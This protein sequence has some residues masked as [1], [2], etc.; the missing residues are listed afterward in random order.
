MKNRRVPVILASVLAIVALAGSL[1]A[2]SRPD[3]ISTSVDYTC[4][5]GSRN[6]TIEVDASGG[7]RIV[8]LPPSTSF[9]GRSVGVTKSDASA[10]TVTL[11][12]YGDD[13]ISGAATATLST[14]WEFDA[15]TAAKAGGWYNIRECGATTLASLAI[16]GATTATGAVYANGGVDR[17]TAAALTFG[18]T[19]ATSANFVPPVTVGGG[20]GS[21]GASIAA[22]GNISTNG[23]LTVDGAS[24][25]TGAITGDAAITRTM[26]A[27]TAQTVTVADSGDGSAATATIT[28]TSSLVIVVCNDT[29]GCTMTVGEGSAVTG[30]RVTIVNTSANAAAFSD[31]AGVSELAGAFSMGQDDALNLVYAG[32]T[33]IETGRSNN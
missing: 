10:N 5:S 1:F 33:W 13:T 30:Q 15:L 24:T 3:W 8:Y 4:A 16:S 17:S 27:S 12:P 28:P 18:E 22:N 2:Q 14:R 32:S 7:N 19:N 23:T 26:Y 21:T 31:S 11:V 9:P 25:L 6:L 29:D 20:Y